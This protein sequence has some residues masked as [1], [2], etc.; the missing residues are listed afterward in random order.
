MPNFNHD[1]LR[2]HIITYLQLVSYLQLLKGFEGAVL[3]H[4]LG[5][6]VIAAILVRQ[7]DAF[8]VQ[9]IISACE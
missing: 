5:R 2:L 4:N 8:P 6:F 7:V 1:W 9:S 3:H